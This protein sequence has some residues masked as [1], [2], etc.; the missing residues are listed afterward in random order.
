[1]KIKKN[2]ILT[3]G[4]LSMLCLTIMAFTNN[5]TTTSN[6]EVKDIDGN[7]YKTVKIGEQEW[8][9]ENL[10]VSRFRNGDKILHATS[11]KEWK[12]RLNMGLLLGVSICFSS[13]NKI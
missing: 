7:T 4:L 2:N 10:N 9:D 11:V 13:F 6:G 3:I 12:N 8:M 1:M 5:T